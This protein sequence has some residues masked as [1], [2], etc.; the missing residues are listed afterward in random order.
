MAI[1][2]GK[3]NAKMTPRGSMI[4]RMGVSGPLNS[5]YEALINKP[6]INGNELIGN[7]TNADLG[8]PTELADLTDDATHRL[9]TDEEKT[10]WDNKSDFSGSYDDLTDKPDIP[11]ELKDLSD[12]STHRL[13]TDTEKTTWNN[14]SDFSGSYTDLTDKP[15]IPDP[16]IQSDWNQSDNTKKD[17]IKNKPTIPASQVNSD[18]NASSGVAEILNKPTLGTAAAKD[19]TNAVTQNSTDIVESGA[20]W[21]AIN[22]LPTPMVF[23]GTLGV[24]GTITS[25]P[26]ASASNEGYTYK[27]ITDGTYDGKSAK[28]GDAFTSNG[29]EWVLFPSGDE[30]FTDT[31]R[32]IKVNDT[33]L[34]GSSITTGAVNFKSGSNVTISGSGNDITIEAQDTTYSKVTAQADGLMSKEDFSKLSG[35]ES[36]A[37]VNTVTG[38]KGNAETDYRTGN[39]NITPTNIGLGNVNN[40]SDATKKTNFTGSI[41]DGNTGFVTGGDAYS[42]LSNKVDKDGNKVLST[43]DYTTAEK[44]KLDGISDEAN[45]VT[46]SSTNGH[47]NIDGVDTT[48]YD[49]TA[50]TTAISGLGDDIEDIQD[51]I[52]TDTTS[53]SGNPLSIVC[54][55]STQN[56][57]NPIV[58]L[59]P[60]QDLHGQDK[61]YPA[62]GGKNLLPM[63]VDGIK[64]LNTTGTWSGNQYTINN[65][66]YTLITDDGNNI[67][68]IEISGSEAASATCLLRLSE[69]IYP[70]GSYI[71][72]GGVSNSCYIY[73]GSS[74]IAGASEVSFTLTNDTKKNFYLRISGGD[75][76]PSGKGTFYPMIRLATESDATFVPYSNICPISGYDK[77]EVLSCGKNLFDS[78]KIKIGTYV[79]DVWSVEFYPSGTVAYDSITYKANTSYTFSGTFQEGVANKS[80]RL[81]VVYTDNTTA[82]M[83]GDS[84]TSAH[85]FVFVSNDAKTISKLDVS[86]ASGNGTFTLTNFQI[87]EG[88]S[89]TTYVPYHKTTDLSEN[90][91]QTVYGGSL[92]LNSGV[93]T[94]DRGRYKVDPNDILFDST[95]LTITTGATPLK[96]VE[97]DELSKY[98]SS[99]MKSHIN[100]GVASM[101]NEFTI[102]NN[103][104]V[105][106]RMPNTVTTSSGATDYFTNNDVYICGLL[107][108]PIEI[109]LTPTELT[110]LKDYAYVS[111]NGT[112]IDL[113]YRNGEMATLE[114]VLDAQNKL[115]EE[116]DNPISYDGKNYRLGMD[117]TGL[118]LYNI[119]DDT[120]AYIQMVTP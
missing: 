70:A 105:K 69:K 120:K 92:D 96:R 25:L 108:T 61:P 31:W 80:Y 12:D 89:A 103:N 26:T 57:I 41:A 49:D 113:D 3:L 65:I 8:I 54:L 102:D 109:Q 10:S 2:Y 110:L 36:G 93:L 53:A 55:K 100:S 5:D 74:I 114:D 82:N 107:A 76:I 19:S 119:T 24:N 44:T 39:I 111:T 101:N 48:V 29:S 52:T 67:I 51:V 4:A 37:Q 90:L 9:V 86:Y 1:N 64:E 17:F 22:N 28:V 15:T 18:W 13:V 88:A 11:D 45:K 83:F 14:K 117:A 98:I 87:E 47:I 32:S 6:Q 30:T 68:K 106:M 95:Y 27:V 40:T 23:K 85:A 78:D 84:D 81:R 73:D 104:K 99:H 94:V 58:T 56:A 115:Q 33:E 97:S 7:K 91:P 77:I 118:Y 72:S 35:V 79:N 34:L 38:V 16:Q 60:I 50:V 42:A 112:R 21:S 116:I 62:G 46:S 59:E 63:T 20:V 75:S 43:N 66:K 71:L